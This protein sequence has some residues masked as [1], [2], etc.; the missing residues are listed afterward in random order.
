[1][2]PRDPS[3][4]ARPTPLEDGLDADDVLLR[5]L[6][7]LPRSVE[8]EHDLWP[9]IAAR[10]DEPRAA[11]SGG[12][13]ALLAASLVAAAVVAF[14]AGRWSGDGVP[15]PALAPAARTTTA[16]P[17]VPPSLAA[18]SASLEGTR[19]EL[20][21]AFLARR[22]GLPPATL[23]LVEE[24]LRTIGEAIA[25]IER[26]LDAHPSDAQLGRRL[27]A[28]KAR[29]IALLEQAQRAAARL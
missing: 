9:V 10:L 22:A 13:I 6:R 5:R 21:R 3:D 20:E 27:V 2:T 11:R 23:A 7:D 14:F 18:A 19:R 29:E 26:A 4:D 1:M 17:A 15:S 8:P 28:Y 16:I 25:E 24:N 12:R